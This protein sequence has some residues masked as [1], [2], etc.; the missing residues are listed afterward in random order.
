MAINLRHRNTSVCNTNAPNHLRSSQ[1]PLGAAS[2]SSSPAT[3]TTPTTTPTPTPTP[4]PTTPLTGKNLRERRDSKRLQR[5]S[6]LNPHASAASLWAVRDHNDDGSTGDYS[7]NGRGDDNRVCFFKFVK[8]WERCLLC[9][10][11]F[12]LVRKII[13]PD[14]SRYYDLLLSVCLT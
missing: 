7:F 9:C 12:L 13:S 10:N 6:V 3:T 11:D 14:Y 4:T 8:H 5:Q 2:S 1:G